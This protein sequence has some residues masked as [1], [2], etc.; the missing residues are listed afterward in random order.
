M[1]GVCSFFSRWS[2]SVDCGSQFRRPRWRRRCAILPDKRACPGSFDSLARISLHS[3][4]PDAAAVG[5]LLARTATAYIVDVHVAV[6]AATA[7]QPVATS[8]PGDIRRIAPELQ[9]IAI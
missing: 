6:C 1:T 3:M 4:G 9:L 2:L 5:L 7:G 8:D